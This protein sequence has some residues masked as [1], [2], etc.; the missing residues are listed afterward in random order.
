MWTHLE[1]VTMI[2]IKLVLV[3]IPLLEYAGSRA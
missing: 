1:V 2:F 3:T